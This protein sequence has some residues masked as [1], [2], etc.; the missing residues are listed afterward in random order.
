MCCPYQALSVVSHF[1]TGSEDTVLAVRPV[2]VGA[3]PKDWKDKRSISGSEK[4]RMVN[5]PTEWQRLF[6][7][8]MGK[9]WDV[10][11]MFACLQQGC[12]WLTFHFQ[13]SQPLFTCNKNAASKSLQRNINI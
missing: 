2:P 4:R 11:E 12:V 8:G 3:G 13:E 9:N 10:Q 7:L 6:R 1:A 5:V